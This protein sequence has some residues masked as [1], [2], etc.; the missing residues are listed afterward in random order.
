[1]RAIDTLLGDRG[2]RRE[3]LG[4]G[5][6]VGVARVEGFGA[7]IGLNAGEEE[8][9]AAA[10]DDRF[11][12]NGCASAVRFRMCCSPRGENATGIEVGDGDSRVAS[13]VLPLDKISDHGMSRLSQIKSAHW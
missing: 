12:P 3:F 2:V 13:G 10:V 4:D 5:R 9:G 7:A 11:K 1:M 8:V 6:S